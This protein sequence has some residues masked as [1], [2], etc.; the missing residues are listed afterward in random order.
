MAAGVREDWK[1]RC[2]PQTRRDS[3]SAVC[4]VTSRAASA[5]HSSTVRTDEPISRPMSQQAVTNASP[6]AHGSHRGG[7]LGRRAAAP[8]RRRRCAGTARRGRSRPRPPARRRPAGRRV[9]TASVSVASTWRASAFISMSAAVAVA[10]LSRKCASSAALPSRKRARNA[11]TLPGA[12][13]GVSGAADMSRPRRQQRCWNW[14]ARRPAAPGCR[15]T[16]SAPRS[17]CR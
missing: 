8:A 7:G 6:H 9:P 1:T 11:A 5:R 12:R 2:A 3:S 16:A 13:V 10:R 4:T 17:R 15:P 14:A